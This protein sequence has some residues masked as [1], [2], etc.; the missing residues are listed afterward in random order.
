[1]HNFEVTDLD[2][3]GHMD[4]LAAS[5]EGVTWLKLD[6]SG[7]ASLSRL[8]AG[9]DQPAPQRGASEI[10]RGQFADGRNYLA[11]IEP[12]HGDK[13][14]VY[15]APDGWEE[16]H[17]LWPRYI[18]DDQLAWGHAI[19]CANLDS[20]DDQELIV[21]VRDDQ[22]ETHRRGLRIYDP[23]T[24]DVAKWPRKLVHPGGVAIADLTVADLDDDGDNDIIAVGRQTHNIKIYWNQLK[25]SVH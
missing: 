18:L 12:W 4:L 10:R 9:Q 8:G 13:I 15:I 2:G 11:T 14:V 21:G 16:A 7:N 22:S 1:M 6:K 17:Q 24:S 20:D 5:F 25:L 3:D 19:A 23:V